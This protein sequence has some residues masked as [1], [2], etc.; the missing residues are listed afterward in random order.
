MAIDEAIF[1][2]AQNSP[3]LP[4]LR[5][6]GWCRPA[7][8]L[9]YFQSISD[10]IDV[11]ACRR[12]GID[13]VFRPTGG[14]AVYHSD[15]F[16]YAVVAG[17]RDALFPPNILGTYEIIGRWL[18]T[19]LRELG[20]HA[21]LAHNERDCSLALLKTSCFSSPSRYELLAGGKKICGS[22][23]VRSR[24]VFLQHGSLLVTFDPSRTYDVMLPHLEPRYD[25][26]MRL[27]KSVTA[28]CEHVQ[29]SG[30]WHVRIGEVLKNAFAECF[31]AT[32]REEDL[33]PDEAR[34]KER[35]LTEKYRRSCYDEGGMCDEG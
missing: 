22:A 11:T 2:Q 5:F 29:V 27:Q 21:E 34:L 23:Q 26:E 25:Q 32:F 14:K 6:Y 3:V 20:I 10:E 31:G 15:D 19:G 30:D 28:L 7:V 1:R 17:D 24:G 9:G 13:I 4:T 16:T 35:L 33:S 12:Q 8:S 18:M